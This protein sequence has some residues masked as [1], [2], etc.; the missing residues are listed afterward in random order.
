MLGLVGD[1]GGTNAR[2]GLVDLSGR[3]S[4]VSCGFPRTES[5]PVSRENHRNIKVGSIQA[6]SVAEFPSFEDALE[7]Y[8]QSNGNP[9]IKAGVVAIATPILDD[10]LVLT[11]GHWAFSQQAVAQR[12]GFSSLRFVN[13]FTALAYSLPW[14]ESPQ[15]RTLGGPEKVVSGGVK[16]VLGPGTGL[17]VSAVIPAG[18]SW[19]ALQGEGGHTT[20][21]AK[22]PRESQIFDCMSSLLQAEE[23]NNH[24]SYER[25]LSGSG[26]EFTYRALMQTD[27]LPVVAKTAPEI[28]E[29]GLSG[30]DPACREILEIFCSQLGQRASDLAVTAGATGGVYIGGGIVPRMQE[31]LIASDFRKAFETKGR[32]TAYVQN[33]PTHLILDTYAALTGAAFLLSVM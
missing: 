2:F 16:A 28:L 32:M 6:L 22:S 23:S 15:L 33:I 30:A 24:L 29:S 26:L 1:V 10:Y 7:N 31:F 18:E 17:G 21:F 11:N 12:F 13:D 14:L 5:S 3:E 9:E 19:V 25:L 8:L 20:L 4:V 27:G